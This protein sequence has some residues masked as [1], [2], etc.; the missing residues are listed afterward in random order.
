MLDQ[1]KMNV[2]RVFPTHTGK[3]LDIR[4]LDLVNLTADSLNRA[5][6]GKTILSLELQANQP[7]QITEANGFPKNVTS[8]EGKYLNNPPHFSPSLS[9]PK[10]T[11]DSLLADYSHLPQIELLEQKIAIHRR[12]QTAARAAWDATQSQIAQLHRQYAATDDPLQRQNLH[13]QIREL[14]AISPPKPDNTQVEELQNQIRKIEKE[15]ALRSEA[16]R[17]ALEL[18]RRQEAGQ[19][20]ELRFMGIVR[21]INLVIPEGKLIR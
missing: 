17:Q 15:A 4:H 20:Q 19:L 14:E 11:P 12:E 9:L 3:P 1:S 8:Y 2:K 13:A 6:S 21:Y 7:F 5:L 18:K 10:A 16:K